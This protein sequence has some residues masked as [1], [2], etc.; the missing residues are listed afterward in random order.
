MDNRKTKHFVIDNRIGEI[1]FLAEKIEELAGKWELPESLTMNINLVLEEAL[2]NIIFYA[3]NDNRKHQIKISMT[4]INKNLTFKIT[5]NGIPFD[6]FS[7][8]QP[9]ISLSAEERPVGGL[10]IF[11]ISKFMDAVHYSRQNNMNILT[12]NKNI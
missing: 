4:L 12:L 1:P 8:P 9:D 2:S 7:L 5:D 6:P 3:Y 10:G 11:L